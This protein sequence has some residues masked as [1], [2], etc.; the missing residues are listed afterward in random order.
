MNLSLKAIEKSVA[1]QRTAACSPSIWSPPLDL[2]IKLNTKS[3]CREEDGFASWGGVAQD[4]LSSWRFEFN[5][6]I[7]IRSVIDAEL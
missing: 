4:R 3:A 1:V 6:F 7:G 5:K 2:W